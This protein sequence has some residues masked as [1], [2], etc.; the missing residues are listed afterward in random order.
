MILKSEAFEEGQKIAAKYTCDGL[1][2]S[3]P[4]SWSG[5]PP[6]TAC[7]AL[8][9]D[10]PDATSG[11][12]VHWVF[13]DI[14][15]SVDSL[16]ERVPAEEKPG[17][18]GTQGTNGFGRVGYRGPCPPSGTHKYCFKLYALDASLDL[19]TGATK[20]RLLEAMDGHIL[21]EC[22]LVARYRR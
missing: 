15:V 19:E 7:L 21:A 20:E 9:C 10:D 22:Q 14:P 11:T 4:L 18:G 8:I 6:N 2:V 1:N 5:V 16:P 12:F 17:T 3:P 13:Y